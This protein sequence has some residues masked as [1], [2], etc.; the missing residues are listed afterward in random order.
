MPIK[1]YGV[2]PGWKGSGRTVP[3]GLA[4]HYPIPRQ[5]RSLSS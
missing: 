1:N 2:L 3:G 5:C 4:L